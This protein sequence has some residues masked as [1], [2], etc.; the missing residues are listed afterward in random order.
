MEDD[1]DWVKQNLNDTDETEP[2][3]SKIV[4]EAFTND[5]ESSTDVRETYFR[6]RKEIVVLNPSYCHMRNRIPSQDIMRP[7]ITSDMINNYKVNKTLYAKTIIHKGPKKNKNFIERCFKNFTENLYF[8]GS[9]YN[10]EK[11]VGTFNNIVYIRRS[12]PFFAVDPKMIL[13]SHLRCEKNITFPF[14]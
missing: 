13:Q 11:T 4:E 6:K 2:S 5:D 12:Q 3:Q 1:L 7:V 8:K 9:A 10:R 14:R